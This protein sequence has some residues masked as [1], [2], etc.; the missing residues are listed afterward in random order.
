MPQKQWKEEEIRRQWL[1][2]KERLPETILGEN[3]NLQQ[4]VGDLQLPS[5]IAGLPFTVN[6]Y[7]TDYS[8]IGFDGKLHREALKEDSKGVV[9]TAEFV[10]GDWRDTMK[11]PIVVCRRADGEEDKRETIKGAL[12]ESL[13][14]QGYEETVRLPESVDNKPVRFFTESSVSPA[15][16]LGVACLGILAVLLAKVGEHRKQLEKRS[17]QMQRDYPDVITKLTLLLE[18]GMT[19]R[20]AW[21]RIVNDYLKYGNS[22]E[23][24]YAYEEMIKTRHQLQLGMPEATAYAQ[25]GRRCGT[26]VYLRFSSVLVQNLEKGTGSIIPLLRKEAEEAMCERKEHARQMGEEAGTKLLLP[27]AGMLILVLLIVMV[28]AF[29]SF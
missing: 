7:S 9:L 12:A 20:Y 5:K 14:E 13:K 8:L 24:R 11:I 26:I 10:Y 21:E 28:P 19:I 15:M 17:E 18:A 2:Q 29:M 22:K 27:M 1:L 4:V 23:K 3:D 25:F 6:W 16:L